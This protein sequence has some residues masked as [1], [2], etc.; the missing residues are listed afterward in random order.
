MHENVIDLRDELNNLSKLHVLDRDDIEQLMIEFGRRIVAVLRIERINAWLFSAEKDSIVSIGEYNAA[1]RSFGKDSFLARSQ[2][3]TY[4]AAISKNDIITVPNVY[5]SAVTQELSAS[6]FRPHNIISLMDVPLRIGGELVGVLCFEKTGTSE[7]RFSDAEQTFALSIGLV[8]ASS[9]EARYRR[10]AQK[11]LDEAMADLA[12]LNADLESFSY[13]VSHDLK[14]P[15]RT[16]LG[17]SAI[18][19]E[20]YRD[21]LDDEGKKVLE[22][23]IRGAERMNS[24]I[25]DLLKLS[26]L[27]RQQLNRQLIDMD[28]CMA[29][30]ISDARE[31]TGSTIRTDV[32]PL[33]PGWAE[34][35]L[36][37]QVWM[38]LVSNAI[39]YSSKTREGLI[40]IGSYS[41][42]HST[43]YYVKDNGIGFDPER[44]S[45]LFGVFQRFHAAN[46]EGNG[47]GLAIVKR[48]VNGHGGKVWAESAPDQGAIF[49][50]S[51]PLA[52]I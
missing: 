25:D 19:N 34:P 38:N 51:L 48:I 37:R 44:A 9:L 8:L 23:I 15:L 45:G 32:N 39:K 20:D 4:F 14:S 42:E 13:S 7:R 46:Y 28:H 21:H 16:V 3:P 36:I 6:Y 30:V 27:G 50:F 10:A 31:Q 22:T 49:F 33:L 12:A 18:L 52:D 17:Y 11:K 26:R 40:T 5:E 24:L 41:A 47:I 1:D 35:S 43:V 29:S 2:F